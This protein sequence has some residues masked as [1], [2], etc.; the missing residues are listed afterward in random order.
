MTKTNTKAVLTAG[1]EGERVEF[2][3]EFT[4]KIGRTLA[5]FANAQGGSI[6]I[7]VSDTGQVVGVKDINKLKSDVQHLINNCQPSIAITMRKQVKHSTKPILAV[8]VQE[9]DN[10]PYAYNDVCY[11]RDGAATRPMRPAEI[12]VAAEQ[13]ERINFD[14]VACKKFDYHKHFDKDKLRLF[15]RKSRV[16]PVQQRAGSYGSTRQFGGAG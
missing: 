10:K 6:Y 12:I 11:T 4:N 8:T 9:G 5:A 14:R 13:S 2:K 16:A 7:G 1:E 15:F 3:A